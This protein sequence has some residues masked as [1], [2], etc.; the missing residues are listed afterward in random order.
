VSNGSDSVG[1]ATEVTSLEER[2]YNQAYNMFHQ[3]SGL[4]PVSREALFDTILAAA[5]EELAGPQMTSTIKARAVKYTPVTTSASAIA[6]KGPSGQ[7]VA[8][9]KVMALAKMLVTNAK[10]DAL[11]HIT[12]YKEKKGAQRWCAW[13]LFNCMH[14]KGW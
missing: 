13:C 9:Q 10:E 7:E 3:Y 8:S 2:V 4:D 14:C 1:P 6:A 5:I 11:S 12:A